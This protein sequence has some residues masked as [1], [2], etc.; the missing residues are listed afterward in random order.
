MSRPPRLH[1]VAVLNRSTVA[2][3]D[4]V[5]AITSAL[6]K[7]V[8]RHFSPTWG[9][10]AKLHFVPSTDMT[11]WSQQWNLVVLDT[12]DEANALGYHDLTPEGLPLGKCFAKT[13][14][15]YGAK[16]SVTMSHELLEMLGDPNINL[17]SQ[18]DDGTIYAYE[19]CDA[20]EADDLGYDIDG[21]TV[22]DFVL[23]EWF[24][25]RPPAAEG[26]LL[27]RRPRDAT[28][29]AGEGWLHLDLPRR[30]LDAALR[31]AAAGRRAERRGEARDRRALRGAGR[32]AACRLTARAPGHG[33]AALAPLD[34]LNVGLRPQPRVPC[35]AWANSQRRM[36]ERPV[37][38]V[39][40]GPDL[41]PRLRRGDLHDRV[42][43]ADGEPRPRPSRVLR[44]LHRP[45]RGGVS[46]QRAGRHKA[47]EGRQWAYLVKSLRAHV[48]VLAIV[49]IVS[50]LTYS[51]VAVVA[52]AIATALAVG[53]ISLVLFGALMLR[54]LRKI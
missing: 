47:A 30:P 35:S 26:R 32:T 7:Q 17:C 9:I 36:N 23:P 43:G 31:R 12:S 6:Q 44:V 33:S 40:Q 20:V 15:A 13:D 21:V 41:R 16:L 46:A 10:G 37:A 34:R 11:S 24:M 48:A 3:D 5:H 28:L 8:D 53:F 27:A 50:S 42:L 38:A 1:R 54:V 18:A 14:L 52:P 19:N 22:S 49:L 45:E 51:V 29:R 25:S 39:E 4:E 2:T